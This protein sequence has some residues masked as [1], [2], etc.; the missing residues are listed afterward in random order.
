[1]RREPKV[2][3]MN[4]ERSNDREWAYD[5]A[6]LWGDMGDIGGGRSGATNLSQR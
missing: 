5:N 6:G 2:R 3:S 1:V 4:A